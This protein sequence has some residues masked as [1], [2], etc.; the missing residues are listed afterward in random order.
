MFSSSDNLL[1]L[2]YRI[3][4]FPDNIGAPF[5][6]IAPV[7]VILVRVQISCPEFVYG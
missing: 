4:V 3:S 1:L 7:H 2:F 5:S 6:A